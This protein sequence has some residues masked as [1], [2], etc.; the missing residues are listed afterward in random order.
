MFLKAALTEPVVICKTGRRV[1]VLLSW[2]EYER[3]STLEEDWWA[4]KPARAE[5]EGYPGPGHLP[6]SCGAG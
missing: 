4:R 6:G 3:L 2:P 1:A 5:L